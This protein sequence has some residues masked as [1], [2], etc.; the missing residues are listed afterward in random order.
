MVMM[1]FAAHREDGVAHH[2]T[3]RLVVLGGGEDFVVSE[4]LEDAVIAEQHPFVGRF[5][6][7]GQQVAVHHG[8][9]EH[10]IGA[11]HVLEIG[12]RA[13]FA[14]GVEDDRLVRNIG[15]FSAQRHCRSFGDREISLS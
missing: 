13:G 15:V 7:R 3:D 2:Q 14:G 10:R 12:V 4:G 1:F 9:V 8:P 6:L 5:Q 11:A